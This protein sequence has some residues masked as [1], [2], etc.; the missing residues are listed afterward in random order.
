MTITGFVWY[1][2]CYPCDDV[3]NPNQAVNDAKENYF[4]EC[5]VGDLS[6][7]AGFCSDAP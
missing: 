7:N 1:K 3:A 2:D 4:L 5:V 6:A